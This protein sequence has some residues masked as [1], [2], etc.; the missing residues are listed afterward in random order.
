MNNESITKE[1]RSIMSP[2]AELAGLDPRELDALLSAEQARMRFD[3]ARGALGV[4]A[5]RAAESMRA[6]G[7][8]CQ[9]LD[10]RQVMH[11]SEADKQG[12]IDAAKVI[13]DAQRLD[14]NS[15]QHGLDL[16]RS[17]MPTAEQ[18]GEALIVNIKA[19]EGK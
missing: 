18:A 7:R 2:A 1:A 12:I 11:L 17:T 10:W 16:M 4:S 13:A 19:M 6:F 15:V 9:Q 8:A 14:L 3:E 5:N